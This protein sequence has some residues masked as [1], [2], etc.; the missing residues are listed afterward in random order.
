MT[1]V[2]FPAVARNFC[3]RHRVQTGSEAHTV[4]YPLGTRGSFPVVKRPV[5]EVDQLPTSST[6]VKNARSYASDY[7]YVLIAWCLIKKRIVLMAW[8][9][10]K[11]S[12]FTFIML[13]SSHANEYNNTPATKLY[14]DADFQCRYNR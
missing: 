6:K 5:L 1:G 10:V 9:L 11:H 13:P 2:R 12:D 8:Y 14:S 4:S 7:P 3:I